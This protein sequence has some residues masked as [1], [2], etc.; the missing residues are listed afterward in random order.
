LKDA[1]QKADDEAKR[2]F[3]IYGGKESKDPPFGRV[4]KKAKLMVNDLLTVSELS[5]E[6][7][8]HRASTA[9][10]LIQF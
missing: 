1:S 8:H 3:E 4:P 7:K 6:G 10:M 5:K 9:S 2:S